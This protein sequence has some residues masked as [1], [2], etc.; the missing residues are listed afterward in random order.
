MIDA[1]VKNI[2][3]FDVKLAYKGMKQGALTQQKYDSRSSLQ[4]YNQ[5]GYVPVDQSNKGCSETYV[6]QFMQIC[7]IL[8]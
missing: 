3:D 2:T 4:F 7:I 8:F 5:F 6:K 1:F